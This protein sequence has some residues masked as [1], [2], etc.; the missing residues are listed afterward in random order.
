MNHGARAQHAAGRANRA[1][2]VGPAA[3]LGDEGRRGVVEGDQAE[4]LAVAQIELP[5]LA[6]QRRTAFASMASNTG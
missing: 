1:R 2:A 4:E 6:A 3:A 5:K